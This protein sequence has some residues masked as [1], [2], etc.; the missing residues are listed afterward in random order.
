MTLLAR[1]PSGRWVRG[2]ARL[3][4]EVAAVGPSG[5]CLGKSKVGRNEVPH[6][7]L[8][9]DIQSPRE[10]REAPGDNAGDGGNH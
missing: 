8:S 10:M 9:I 1:E 6:V 3:G 2:G 7:S 4:M 5:T